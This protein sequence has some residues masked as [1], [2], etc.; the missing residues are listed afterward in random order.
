M[1]PN[2]DDW[3][4]RLPCYAFVV[5]NVWNAATG[6]TPSFLNY[7]DHLRS[8]GS[9]DIVCRMPAARAF[10]KRVN[11]AIA[12]VRNCLSAARTKLKILLT[13]RVETWKFR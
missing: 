13:L 3:D 7:G 12:R 10:G 4:I 8:P 9:A 6:S 1:S 2:H 11:E 5:H